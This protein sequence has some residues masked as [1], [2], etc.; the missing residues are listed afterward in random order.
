MNKSDQLTCID[1]FLIDNMDKVE[2]RILVYQLLHDENL[3]RNFR[4][5][6][7]MKGAFV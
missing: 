7:S 2:L 6:V 1:N 4:L 3:L 5:Y